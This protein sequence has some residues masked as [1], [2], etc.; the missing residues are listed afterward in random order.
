MAT[1][2]HAQQAGAAG[3]TRAG[4]ANSLLDVAW[5]GERF[6]AVGRN[7]TIIVSP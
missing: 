1:T 5:S 6:A 4:V 2:C 7:G 3:T